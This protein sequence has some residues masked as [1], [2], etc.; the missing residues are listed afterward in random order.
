MILLARA[1]PMFPEV[2]SCMAGML[3][4]SL[5]KFLLALSL[6][7]GPYVLIAAYAGSISSLQNPEPA[8]ITAISISGFLW[9]SW[10]LHHR[11]Q[12]RRADNS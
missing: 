7:S 5:G 3:R 8:I 6:S 11:K 10:F 12:K 9:L 2:T 1:V 4:M